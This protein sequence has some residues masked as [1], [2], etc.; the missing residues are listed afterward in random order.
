MCFFSERTWGVGSRQCLWVA[1]LGGGELLLLGKTLGLWDPLLAWP[2]YA[3]VGDP[4]AC[5]WGESLGLF[6][7]LVSASYREY[8]LAG[9]KMKNFISFL[10]FLFFSFPNWVSAKANWYKPTPSGKLKM[11]P[12]SL[13]RL[14]PKCILA[15][16]LYSTLSQAWIPIKAL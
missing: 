14:I 5:S 11:E 12:S 7:P 3:W 9:F 8:N 13:K 1:V 4:V 16:N 15:L 10:F 2:A 6:W